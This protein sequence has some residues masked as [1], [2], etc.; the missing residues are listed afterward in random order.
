MSETTSDK[1]PDQTPEQEPKQTIHLKSKVE[2]AEWLKNNLNYIVAES[3]MS[4]KSHPDIMDEDVVRQALGSGWLK[5]NTLDSTF[6]ATFFDE[7]TINDLRE[8][9]LSVDEGGLGTGDHVQG[10][11]GPDVIM[12]L[13]RSVDCCIWL[14]EKVANFISC[15]D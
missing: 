3:E 13:Y 10:E 6:R 15:E 14:K 11:H 12:R 4:K 1:I 8:R 5:V 9:N 7:E 2:I